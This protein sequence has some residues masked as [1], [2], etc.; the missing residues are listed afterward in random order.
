MSL[1]RIQQKIVGT[2]A[3]DG[4]GDPDISNT[5]LVLTSK[6]PWFSTPFISPSTIQTIDGYTISYTGPVYDPNYVWYIYQIPTQLDPTD[7]HIPIFSVITT[8]AYTSG[9]IVGKLGVIFVSFW[10][11]GVPTQG[12]QILLQS[13]QTQNKI[14][15]LDVSVLIANELLIQVA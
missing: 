6:Q 4:Y 13:L 9:S 3:I 15:L 2:L 7:R 11:N 8:R 10:S 5:P 1:Y 12:A 14:F